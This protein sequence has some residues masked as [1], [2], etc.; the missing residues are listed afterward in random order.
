MKNNTM[1]MIGNAHI[2]PVWLWQ[3]LEGAQEVRAT[4]RSALDRMKESDDFVFVASSAAL[5]EW[6]EQVEPEMFA[7][8]VQRVAEGR[9]AIVGGWWVEPDCNIPCGESFVR[10]ALY[11][12]RYFKDRF[13]VIARVGYNVDSFGHHGMLPQI[14]KKSGLDFYVF[15]RPKPEEKALP[16]HIFWWT[17]DDGSCVL[18]FRILHS[19]GSTGRD[20][21]AHVSR[22]ASRATRPG[23]K[24]MCFY[25]VGNHGGG[26]TVQNIESIRRLD[27]DPR[28]PRLE[29]STPERFFA[30]LSA[31][32]PPVAVVHDDLQHHASG[33]YAAH[34]G[35]KRWNR[36]AENLLLAAE[37]Y[38]TIARW[39]TGLPYPSG[40]ELAWK[41]VL[42]SQFHDVLAGTSLEPAYDDA[43]HLYGE[44]MAIASR[45]QNLA[46]QSISSR[47]HIEP[48]EGVVPIVVFNSHAWAHKANVQ[49]ETALAERPATLM[50]DEGREVPVQTVRSQA[51]TTFRGRLSFVADLPPMGYRT[52]RL[53]P[54]PAAQRFDP[55]EA[56]DTS[57]E[58]DL[59]RLEV[60]PTTGY[61]TSLHDKQRGVEILAGDGAKPIVMRDESD[62]W[63]HGVFRFHDESGA[64]TG[65][66]V[67]LVEQG[68]VAATIRVTSQYGASHL[69]QDFTM[70]R[71]LPR[72]DVHVTVDW[73][74]RFS[75]LKLQF[76]VNIQAT[77]ATYEIPYG[78]IQRPTNGEEEPGQAWLDLSGISPDDGAAFGLSLLNDGKYS[79][80]VDGNLMSLTVLRSPIYAHHDPY[81]P[82][83]DQ[84]YAFIDHGIQHFTYS[85]L[86]HTGGWRDAQP[87]RRAAE[88]NQPPIALVESSHPEGTLPQRGSFLAV[89]QDNIIVSAVKKAEDDERMVIRCYETNGTP[90]RA[91]IRMPRWNRVIETEFGAC[92]IK[93]LLVPR[94][95]AEPV[96]GTNLLEW[97]A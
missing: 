53:V 30:Q 62:T 16:G 11:G 52:Y 85:L 40:F 81:A 44:A 57:V 48:G 33:C 54:Q 97:V 8:I 89:D 93:T 4:F 92:E 12:Q 79:F 15:M 75:V 10:Q 6:V 91:T 80:D 61:V 46:V 17:S 14:L 70:Y 86:P 39:V 20:L 51:S 1:H 64:F 72:I 73:R 13:G 22:C 25:G 84:D 38:S 37:K 31:S 42:F 94:D 88:L 19:Y 74:E 76:P 58:N 78:H 77:H 24:I 3:W 35:V 63:S 36:K 60:D 90:T 69:I 29:F 21:E 41:N 45:A 23:A 56:S 32:D 50:D 18:A 87:A 28:F 95:D 9:W 67:R 59:Y 47:I 66:T 34:S 7:E 2:D 82:D 27:A 71:E 83:L 5:Y 96:V 43:N 68:P 55:L 49:L 26:P 65:E